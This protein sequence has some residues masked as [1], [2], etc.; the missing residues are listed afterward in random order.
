MVRRNAS[1]HCLRSLISVLRYHEL[2]PYNFAEFK[3]LFYLVKF[4]VK[5]GENEVQFED[6]GGTRN[7]STAATSDSRKQLP[8]SHMSASRG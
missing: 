8:P 4:H 1:S 7:Y 6:Y 3:Q 2:K 5:N